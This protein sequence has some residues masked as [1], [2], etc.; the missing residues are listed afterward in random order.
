MI[1]I[2]IYADSYKHFE[3][4]IKEYEKRLW[5]KLQIIKLKPSKNSN[6]DMVI[7]EETADIS[8]ILEKEKW[9]KVVLNPE[10]EIY[11]TAEFVEIIEEWKMKF[12]NIIFCIWWAYGFDYTKLSWKFDLMLS[13]W[14]ITMPHS[15]ALLVLTE[16]VYRAYMIEKGSGYHK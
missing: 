9:Y 12:W 5:K 6:S 2:Y 7:K 13:F 1:K 3:T 14:N 10:W 16:Q 4:A 11:N 15:L 8:K